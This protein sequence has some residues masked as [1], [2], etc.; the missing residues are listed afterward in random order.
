MLQVLLTLFFF[1]AAALVPAG[2]RSVKKQ[3][4]EPLISHAARLMVF[5]PHPDDETLGAGGL[6]QRVLKSGGKVKVVFMTN[7]EGY[8]A[9]VKREDHIANPSAKDYREYGVLRRQEALKATATLGMQAP[10][11][12]FLGFPDDGLCYLRSA[13]FT[14]RLLYLSPATMEDC[15]PKSEGIIPHTGYT[16][17]GLISEMERLITG[18]GP[19]LVA[20]TA[21]QDWHPDHNATYF[22]VKEALRRWEKKHSNLKPMMIT[23]LVHF[24]Q[25]PLAQGSGAGSP[26]NPPEYFPGKGIQWISF[27]LAPD[28]VETKRKA[29]LDYHSQMLVMDRYLMSFARS[30]ELYMLDK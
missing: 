13:F 10:D 14:S 27:P 1:A 30:N 25:W 23:F 8:A 17:K 6:I 4:L 22:F 3:A 28:E 2:A 9:G 26:L 11:V 15:P 20:T 24:E 19:T 5:S 29:I 7:G 12:I 16:G 21:A 18:F